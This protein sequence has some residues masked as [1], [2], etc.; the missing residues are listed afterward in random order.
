MELSCIILVIPDSAMKLLNLHTVAC[1]GKNTAGS[2]LTPTDTK[3]AI[4]AWVVS[5]WSTTLGCSDNL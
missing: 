1:S 3:S 2:K 4:G 5:T